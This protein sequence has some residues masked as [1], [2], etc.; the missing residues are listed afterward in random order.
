MDDGLL[1]KIRLSLS[2]ANRILVVSHIRPD[3]DAIGSLLGLGMALLAAGKDVQMVLSDKLPAGFRH[4]PGSEQVRARPEGHFDLSVVVD[5]SDLERVGEALV[6]RTGNG[7]PQ[8]LPPDINIDH[9]VTNE[10][11]ARYN[12]VESEAVATSEV[13]SRYLTDF[14]LTLT[15]PVADA[16]LTGILTDTLGFR[17]SNMTPG[18][19]R[20]AANLMEA[21]ANLSD[22]YR[23]ALM[24]RSFNAAR[25]WGAG[26]TRLQR[27]GPMVWATLTLDDRRMVGY[28]GRDDADIINVVSSIDD[29]EVSLVFVEQNHESVKVSWRAQPGYDVS[30]VALSFGGG[31]HKVAAGAD[32]PGALSEV[33]EKV[34]E[35]TRALFA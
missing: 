3:G 25:Y 2:E 8:T 10:M 12:L 30:R 27:D 23:F 7:L 28:P 4:L 16:L 9:H 33:Q 31:G 11:F 24:S 5:C 32:I 20:T 18:V 29:A 6:V 15:Q 17:T 21:G 26:L 14:G 13:L 1:A 19:L 34:L 35:A 22:L